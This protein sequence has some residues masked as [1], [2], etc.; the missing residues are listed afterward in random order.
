LVCNRRRAARPVNESDFPLNVNNHKDSIC[1]SNNGTHSLFPL[2]HFRFFI[3]LWRGAISE[4]ADLN[5]DCSNLSILSAHASASET[6][7]WLLSLMD[8][9]LL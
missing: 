9:M 4:A 1:A 2:Q 5:I 8:V 3:A 6:N 7:L